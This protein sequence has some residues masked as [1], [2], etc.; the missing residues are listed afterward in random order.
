[1]CILVGLAKFKASIRGKWPIENNPHL[2]YCG[3]DNIAPG[4]EHLGY[5]V[6]IRDYATPA[7]IRELAVELIE[8]RETA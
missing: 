7:V 8:E 5:Q 6:A 2:G 3:I 4:T 1:M